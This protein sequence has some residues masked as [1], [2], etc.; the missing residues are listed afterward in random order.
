MRQQLYSIAL[1][2]FCL[3]SLSISAQDS[4]EQRADKKYESLA[5]IDA[6]KI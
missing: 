6:I 1:G 3:L 5:Y 2:A 4:R